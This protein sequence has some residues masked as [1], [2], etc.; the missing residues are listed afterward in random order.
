MM[1]TF[2]NASI[3]ATLESVEQL[4]MYFRETTLYKMFQDEARHQTFSRGTY[5][6]SSYSG[7]HDGEVSYSSSKDSN[8]PYT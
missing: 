4:L 2:G 6:K 7:I 5:H 1:I 8:E 3:Y